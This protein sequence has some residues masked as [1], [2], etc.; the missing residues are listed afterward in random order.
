MEA[1]KADFRRPACSCA[2]ALTC[3]ERHCVLPDTLHRIA[4]SHSWEYMYHACLRYHT[5]DKLAQKSSFIRILP[6]STIEVSCSLDDSLEKNKKCYISA[7]AGMNKVS[8]THHSI[9]PPYHVRP[10][11]LSDFEMGSNNDSNLA[12]R[13]AG[14]TR[15][16]FDG[17]I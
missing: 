10:I 2:I 4:S 15:R 9:L 5:L 7:T 6:N 13:P 1:G 16:Y 8:S 12:C 3:L 14:S 17:S 11:T